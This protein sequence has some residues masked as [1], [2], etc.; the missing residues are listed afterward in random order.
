MPAALSA[1]SI[2]PKCCTQ[3]LIMLCTESSW[4]RPPRT[5]R[6]VC[7]HATLSAPSPR[8]CLCSCRQQAH[9]HPVKRTESP[10]P[11]RSHR[12]RQSPPRRGQRVRRRHPKRA[13][14]L[15]YSGERLARCIA[16]TGYLKHGP[17]WRRHHATIQ[18][19]KASLGA[20]AGLNRPPHP[21]SGGVSRVLELAFSTPRGKAM[22]TTWTSFYSFCFSF[23]D[24]PLAC[25]TSHGRTVTTTTKRSMREHLQVARAPS[26][27]SALR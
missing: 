24:D 10:R 20:R 23:Q 1:Q 9:S 22:K 15:C 19:V 13:T 18:F 4:P 17:V 7:L 2:R 21:N 3:S 6:L 8:Q 16:P 27:L 25:Y 26:S 14:E 12:R 11:D 5:T